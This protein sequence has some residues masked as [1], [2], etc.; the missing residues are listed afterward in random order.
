MLWLSYVNNNQIVLYNLL[1]NLPQLELWERLS[2]EDAILS[3]KIF[4]V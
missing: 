1:L 3:E 4:D 2:I